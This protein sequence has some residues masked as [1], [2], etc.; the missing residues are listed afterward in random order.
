M[1]SELSRELRNLPFIKIILPFIF[2]IIFGISIN[3]DFSIPLLSITL[4]LVFGFI[5]L[6]FRYK[7]F[8]TGYL[9]GIFSSLIFFLFGI[10]IFSLNKPPVFPVSDNEITVYARLY[11]PLEEKENSCKTTLEVSAFR[12]ADSLWH[13]GKY[14]II[15]YIE[16]DSAL[17]SLKYGD[18]ILFKSRI[19]EVKN[20]GNP[21]E[22]DYQTFLYRRGITAQT[23]IKT[24]AWV[25]THK[26]KYNYL[27][28]LAFNT[29]KSLIKIYKEKGITG[30]ELAVLQ[31]L[32]LGE[33]GDLTNETRRSYVVS[34]AM[35]VLA[36]S[37]LH[38]GIIYV[39]LNLIFGFL[40][41]FRTEKVLYGKFFKALIIII[42]IWFF[43]MLSGL[44]PSVT[45]AAV[46]FT[47]FAAGRALNR[48]LNIYNSLASS[49][50]LLL[51][52]NP[53]LI[54][55]VGF[56]LS[57][58]AV[59]SIVYFQ[60]KINQLFTIKQVWLS[61]LWELTSVSLAAQIGTTPI[62]LYYF[63]IFP[64]WFF[65]TNLFVIFTATFI[66]YGAALLFITSFIPYVSDTVAYLLKHLVRAMNY[67]VEGVEAMPFSAFDNIFF[68]K[69]HLF[70][71]YALFISLTF[72]LAYRN[73]KYLK[74]SLSIILLLL[75]WRNVLNY[76]AGKNNSFTVYNIHKY[77]AYHFVGGKTNILLTDS[78]LSEKSI[79]FGI[80]N[81]LLKLRR[82]D[83]QR[84]PVSENIKTKI[85]QK[86]NN[87][88]LFSDKKIVLISDKKQ[89]QYTADMPLEIDYLI[90]SN[91]P[92]ISINDILEL[93]HPK[94]IIF[95]SSNKYNKLKRWESECKSL[96]QNFFSV[97][98]SGAFCLNFPRKK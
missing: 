55:E 44:S 9:S 61:K 66:V 37:G 63:H 13:S 5:F 82:T 54:T 83:L 78:T 97:S 17:A 10:L 95:D 7:K 38:V 80:K 29:R 57:Y 74:I 42:L 39:I 34:G 98:D 86:K 65:I 26:H 3:A 58:L 32:T 15:A 92:Y 94:L 23:Y 81:N 6:I 70:A 43:A 79:N 24:D 71:L 67:M 35:H 91:N 45:R 27:F 16:K 77:P 8:S 69:I 75:I 18:Y 62:S 20:A 59:L 14:R 25:K 51:L 87:Y 31:A 22:F 68:E 73:H 49:A 21:Y 12:T 4:G 48:P 76:E 19:S 33:K 85:L 93:Y 2:G 89:V 1:L 53:F 84:L 28:N 41:N 30:Q 60:P 96:N 64:T 50:F 36:V 40:E 11:E 88:I 72:W 47:F 90:L 56:Q 52:F 46:M